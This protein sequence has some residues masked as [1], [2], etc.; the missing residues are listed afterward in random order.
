MR[1]IGYVPIFLVPLAAS[2]Q[3]HEC[4]LNPHDPQVAV[5]LAEGGGALEL[6]KGAEACRLVLDCQARAA[7]AKL[8]YDLATLKGLKT[9]PVASQITRIVF[10]YADGAR[11]SCQVIGAQASK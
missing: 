4:A 11:Q 8:S 2:A 3:M 5:R 9:P 10:E 6:S 1:K 7:P